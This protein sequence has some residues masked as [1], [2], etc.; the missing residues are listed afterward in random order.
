[1]NMPGFSA[2]TSLYKTGGHYRTTGVFGQT[3]ESV[4][5]V[6]SISNLII[7]PPTFMHP[8]RSSLIDFI[9]SDVLTL[10]DVRSCCQD[11]LSSFPCADESCR[12]QRLFDCSRKCNAEVIGGCGCPPGRAVCEG[13]CC[14]ARRSMHFDRMLPTQS[15]V[16]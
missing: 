3:D 14:S 16:Q 1:M 7:S 6:P 12:R 15:G 4:Y 5:P 8:L 11:C 2:E 10:I 9:Y 13:L